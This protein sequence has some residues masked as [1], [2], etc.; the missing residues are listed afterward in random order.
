MVEI[1]YAYKAIC[2]HATRPTASYKLVFMIDV[3]ANGYVIE[4]PSN[5]TAVVGSTTSFSCLYHGYSTICWIRLYANGSRSNIFNGQRLSPD[6]SGRY[7]VDNRT[8]GVSKLLISSVHVT[9]DGSYACKLC[10]EQPE[11]SFELKVVNASG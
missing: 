11:Y 1:G 2:T 7:I 3:A 6:F 5:T 4:G 9:D 8:M 10:E